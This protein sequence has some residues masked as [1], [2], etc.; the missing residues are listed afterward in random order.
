MIVLILAGGSGT[1]LWPVS[2]D[3][4]PKQF[5]T[6]NGESLLSKTYKRFLRITDKKDI[7]IVTN[8]KYRFYVISDLFKINPD[9]ERNIILEPVAKNT[10]GA[11]LLAIKFLSEIKRIN[12]QSLLFVTPSDHIISDDNKFSLL[13]NRIK[14]FAH[15]YIVTFGIKPSVPHT[16]YG[17]IKIGKKLGSEVYSIERFTEKPDNKTAISYFESGKYL[18]NSGMFFFSIKIM[19]DELKKYEKD[20]YNFYRFK[21]DDLI[22]NFHNLK[23]ISIDYSV[24][25]KTKKGVVVLGDF[26]WSD[27]G[28]WE[29]FYEI[30]PKDENESVKVGNIISRNLINSMIYST[31]K[32]LIAALDISDLIIV[33]TED[34]LLVMKKG[35]GEIVKEIVKDIR[36]RNL[37][38]A[39][40]HITVYRPWGSY[41]V[42]EEGPRYK[43]K[44]IFVKP[45]HKLSEQMHYHRSEHWVVIKG[46]AK[47]VMD[48]KEYIVH[49]NE[50]IYVGKSTKHR[51]ENPGKVDLELIEVQNGEYVGEDDIVRFN[52]IYGRR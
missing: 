10:T 52:D 23:S 49:E 16:G 24:M 38:E 11:I 7:Y 15:K 2:R 34:A 48:N 30:M 21:F 6:I 17:Y 32:K 12:L 14:V 46:T 37:K 51:L 43:I 5:I 36:N 9:I 41:T 33:D 26:G 35:S 47:V 1:R 4:F 42:L 39:F 18:W 40:E 28:G 22:K 27:I 29:S 19:L 45:G 8:E 50:S 3:N 44:R 13:C 25:E 31:T 20:I